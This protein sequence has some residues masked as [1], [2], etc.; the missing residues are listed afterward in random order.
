MSEVS[1]TNVQL[2]ELNEAIKRLDRVS[3]ARLLVMTARHVKSEETTMSL[4][5]SAEQDVSV[6]V[7]NRF[8][9]GCAVAEHLSKEEGNV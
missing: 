8:E 4:L 6:I 5:G 7:F 9:I 2:Y 1:L 3:A